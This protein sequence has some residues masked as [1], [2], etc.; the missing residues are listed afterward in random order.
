MYSSSKNNNVKLPHM[1]FDDSEHFIFVPF[2]LYNYHT[3][4]PVSL[5]NF[6]P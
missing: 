5:V 2:I 1:R 6:F 4:E 3:K